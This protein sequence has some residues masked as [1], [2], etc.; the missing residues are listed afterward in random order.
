[1]KLQKGNAIETLETRIYSALILL[2]NDGYSH[3]SSN[4]LQ[5][6][7]GYKHSDPFWVWQKRNKSFKAALDRLHKK[8]LVNKDHGLYSIITPNQI[9]EQKL[10]TLTTANSV[11]Q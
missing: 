2:K 5:Y 9:A 7:L 11:V 1:M 8:G 3:A 6:A 4:K 10:A